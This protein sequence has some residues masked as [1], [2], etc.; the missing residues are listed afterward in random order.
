MQK[1]TQMSSFGKNA[2]TRN[3]ATESVDSHKSQK[4]SILL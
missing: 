4:S 1:R 3:P 2:T